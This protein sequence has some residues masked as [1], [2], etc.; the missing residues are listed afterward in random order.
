MSSVRMGSVSMMAIFFVRGSSV[1]WL[2]LSVASWKV[3][4]RWGGVRLR[5]VRVDT[6]DRHRRGR[7]SAF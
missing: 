4:E 6:R 3:P 7:F 1:G 5:V 2:L